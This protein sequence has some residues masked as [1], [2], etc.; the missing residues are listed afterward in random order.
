MNELLIMK[1]R[2]LRKARENIW[3]MRTALNCFLL[4]KPFF[5]FPLS[6]LSDF[7]VYVPSNLYTTITLP[8]MCLTMPC[9]IYLF[10]PHKSIPLDIWKTQPLLPFKLLSTNLFSICYCASYKMYYFMHSF[11]TKY[12]VLYYLFVIFIRKSHV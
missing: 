11:A 12:Q 9:T 5:Y 7:H 4:L 3:N 2:L 6:P 8:Q 1:C 10:I